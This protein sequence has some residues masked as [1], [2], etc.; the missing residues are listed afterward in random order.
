LST[1][2]GIAGFGGRPRRGASGAS[3]FS[4]SLVVCS[5]IALTFGFE[6][7]SARLRE[8]E[9]RAHGEL[10]PL[11]RPRRQLRLL[12]FEFLDLGLRRLEFLFRV[13]RGLPRLL[14]VVVI[15]FEITRRRK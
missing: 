1:P 11:W 6:R 4:D 2:A 8:A 10:R 14:A 3:R 5:F 12:R 15:V 13:A 7:K 9:N